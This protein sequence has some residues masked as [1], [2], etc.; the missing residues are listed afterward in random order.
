MKKMHKSPPPGRRKKQQQQP[1]PPKVVLVTDTLVPTRPMQRPVR[2]GQRP[3]RQRRKRPL[4]WNQGCN[5]ID[6]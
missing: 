2:G 4:N 5:S 3:R 6:I 1:Q